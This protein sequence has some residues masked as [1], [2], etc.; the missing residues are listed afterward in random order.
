MHQPSLKYPVRIAILVSG[1]GTNAEKI[2]RYCEESKNMEV[3]FWACNRRGAGAYQRAAQA[4]AEIIHLADLHDAQGIFAQKLKAERVDAIVLAGFLQLI[5]EWLIDAY[6]EKIINIHPSLLPKFGGKGMYGMHVHRAVI[7]SG[8]TESGITI[9]LVNEVFDEGRILYQFKCPVR[10]T[11]S[12]E[13][14]A[15]RVQ[16]LEHAHFARCVS[17][18]FLSLAHLEPHDDE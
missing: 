16:K 13:D 15:Q 1:S 7:S 4:G 18:Y 2:Q 14:L 12:P 11:D 8:E 9:H 3:A 6:P 5:P 10:S 17:S